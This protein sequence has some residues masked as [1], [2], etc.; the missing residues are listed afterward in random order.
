[1]EDLDTKVEIQLFVRLN[2]YLKPYITKNNL[3]NLTTEQLKV[4]SKKL[5][6]ICDL[7]SQLDREEFCFENIAVVELIVNDLKYTEEEF[8]ECTAITKKKV[9]KR[10]F[11]RRLE[12][13]QKLVDIL[14]L[15]R[16]NELIDMELMTDFWNNSEHP[17]RYELFKIKFI[18]SLLEKHPILKTLDLKIELDNKHFKKFYRACCGY[19][20]LDRTTLKSHYSNLNLSTK[21]SGIVDLDILGKIKL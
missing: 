9:Y 5:Y 19:N 13:L 2:E 8:E 21:L 3:L 12:S 6:A 7:I 14:I 16:A 4:F 1:M 15:W 17:V 10:D 11:V 20:F 18:Y